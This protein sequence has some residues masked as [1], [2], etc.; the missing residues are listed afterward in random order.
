MSVPSRSI[1][2]WAT[3]AIANLALLLAGS[4]WAEP[5]QPFAVQ[6]SKGQ[7]LVW[8]VLMDAEQHNAGSSAKDKVESQGLGA[9]RIV[10]DTSSRTLEYEFSWGDLS[11]EAIGIELRGPARA[12]QGTKR[13]LTRLP[14]TLTIP[15]A[16][17]GHMSG[18]HE[19]SEQRQEGF[20][21]LPPSSI[22]VVLVSGGGYVTIK[23]TTHPDGE[24]R[25]NLGT[26]SSVA[27]PPTAED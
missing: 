12:H 21:P 14:A 25:G 6:P 4:A 2:P 17:E 1:A 19:L 20:D 24:I 9:G 5:H 18:R 26:A 11:G 8:E 23:T 3:L 27:T 15:R 16:R 7:V 10:Y 13:L 22:L